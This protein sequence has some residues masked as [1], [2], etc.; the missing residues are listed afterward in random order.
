MFL[1]ASVANEH[2]MF[3]L[4]KRH[5]ETSQRSRESQCSSSVYTRF[6]TSSIVK[7]S[8][9]VISVFVKLTEWLQFQSNTDTLFLK[10]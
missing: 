1:E 4:P 10:Q 7:V 2:D 9:D 3:G 8:A 5:I 6:L